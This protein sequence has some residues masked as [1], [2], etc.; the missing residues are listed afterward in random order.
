MRHVV[1]GTVLRAG[2]F[3]GVPVRQHCFA[4]EMDGGNSRCHS[5][6]GGLANEAENVDVDAL[7]P[8]LTEIIG[9]AEVPGDGHEGL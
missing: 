2:P 5:L 9:S 1:G 7:E 8:W 4:G 3:A 6:L